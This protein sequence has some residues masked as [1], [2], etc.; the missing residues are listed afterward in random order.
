MVHPSLKAG[1]EG[2]CFTAGNDIQ[3]VISAEVNKDLLKS[4]NEQADLRRVEL[5]RY[6][7][8]GVIKTRILDFTGMSVFDVL[9]ACL[10]FYK[11]RGIRRH[12][13]DHKF[14]EGF[15]T[16]PNNIAITFLGS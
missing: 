5:I 11:H 2:W 4:L 7:K 16:P 13:G 12:I 6:H 3:D 15:M 9:M 1:N 14:F 10:R 8:L